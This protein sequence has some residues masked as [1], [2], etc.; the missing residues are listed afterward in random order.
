M[1]S[2]KQQV[3]DL[4]HDYQNAVYNAV[5]LVNAKSAREKGFQL[6][7]E[8]SG[9]RAGYLDSLKQVRY[10]FHGVGCKIIT[11]EFTVDFDYAQEGGCSGI[12]TWFLI[13]FLTSNPLIQAKYPLLIS[14]EQLEQILRELAGDGLLTRHLHNEHDQRYYL[15]AS[16]GDLNLPTVTL[17]MPDEEVSE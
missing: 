6:H 11:P 14:D 13:D 4:I 7:D 2:A 12:D 16:I 1:P 3:V 5:A 8:T 9:V 10:S 17:Y 15:T